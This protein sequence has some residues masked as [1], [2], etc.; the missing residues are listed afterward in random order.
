M[1]FKYQARTKDGELQVGY[2]DAAS[3]DGAANVLQSHNLFILSL[4]EAEKAHWYD[5]L[6][7]FFNRVSRRDMIIFTRQ[8][9]TLL[10]SDITLSRTLKTL[11]E[12]T[13]NSALKE[14]VFQMAED[15]DAGLS[16]S[17]ALDRQ[18]GVFPTFFAEMVRVA[19]VSGSLNDVVAL[20]ADYT[21]K[22]GTLA[23]RASSALIYPGI[24]V[25][26]VITSVIMVTFVFPQITPIFA[27]S[28]VSL[29]VFTS[30]L[31][32]SGDFISKWW[33]PIILVLVALVVLILDYFQ[34]KEGQ[35]FLDDMKIR[36]PIL[37][38]VY[39]PLIM[40]RFANAAVILVRGG[41]PLMQSM[42]IISYMIG[43]VVYRDVIQALAEDVRRG[44][45]LSQS[46]ANYPSY[47]PPIVSQMIAVGETTGKIEH[48]FERLSTFYSREADAV[49]SNLVDLI[50]PVLMVGVGL[51]VGLL[52][53]SVL[54]PLYQLTS[55]FQF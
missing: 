6:V 3:R 34:T 26:L 30:V 36:L 27:Q 4:E 35:A 2:V 21:E 22:E 42:E 53:A 25:G 48:I 46:V 31:L 44:G 33:L 28:N 51:L 32:K 37:S 52:F 20:L 16:L 39:R 17:Q 49:I 12:Q 7:S 47:F 8:L 23:S 18:G 13:R 45:L 14:A 38:R 54:L 11:Y 15:V 10:E 9:A 55:S 1:K 24:V 40:A 29:P 41:I 5:P 19:E 50:Q 43:N